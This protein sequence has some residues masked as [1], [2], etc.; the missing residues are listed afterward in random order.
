MHEFNTSVGRTTPSYAIL[1]A[2]RVLCFPRHGKWPL[3]AESAATHLVPM[4]EPPTD[5]QPVVTPTGKMTLSRHLKVDFPTAK[6]AFLEIMLWFGLPAGEV[7]CLEMKGGFNPV[8][9]G[10]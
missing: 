5:P 6:P 1:C 4:V 2:N 7:C 8:V 9:A 3:V 10:A